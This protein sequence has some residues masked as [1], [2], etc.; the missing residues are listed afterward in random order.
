[1]EIK[2]C[3]QEEAPKY[4]ASRLNLETTDR[5]ALG[6]LSPGARD[7]RT[8]SP[9]SPTQDLEGK[10]RSGRLGKPRKMP[11]GMVSWLAACGMSPQGLA[12]AAKGPAQDSRPRRRGLKKDRKEVK[13][14]SLE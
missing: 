12:R 2:D 7:N 4:E 3:S 5:G 13:D 8:S 11:K 14:W 10:G 6:I 9:G 1:M